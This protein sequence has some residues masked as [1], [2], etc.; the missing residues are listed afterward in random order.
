MRTI[1]G[2][3]LLLALAPLPCLAQEGEGTG[4]RVVAASGEVA[5][6]GIF[7]RVKPDCTNGEMRITVVERP[8]HGDVTSQ[9]GKTERG[10][11]ARCP[12]L[13]VRGAAVL[14]R[15]EPD[16][17]GEDRVALETRN[18]EGHLERHEFLITVE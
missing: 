11:M 8:A 9:I 2:L 15:S 14:Y 13:E 18:E 1:V 12:E 5:R 10:K 6:L 7:A 4:K 16:Y 17:K 3:A